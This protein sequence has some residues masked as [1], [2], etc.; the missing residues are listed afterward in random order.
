MKLLES[1]KLGCF[2]LAVISLFLIG[3]S[4]ADQT[5]R[6]SLN[7]DLTGLR[8][9]VEKKGAYVAPE[10]EFR[11]SAGAGWGVYFTAER[12]KR[13]ERMFNAFKIPRSLLLCNTS[14]NGNLLEVVATE[15]TAN[16]T[17]WEPFFKSLP[18]N[19]NLIW[20]WS[21]DELDDLDNVFLTNRAREL[22]AEKTAAY[23]RL[24]QTLKQPLSFDEFTVLDFWVDS[25]SFNVEGWYCL[26]PFADIPNHGS[27]APL[28]TWGWERNSSD[29]SHYFS[30]YS[31]DVPE[32][33]REFRIKYK[34]NLNN[35]YALIDYGFVD[36][37]SELQRVDLELPNDDSLVLEQQQYI[38]KRIVLS[39]NVDIV[40]ILRFCRVLVATSHELYSGRLHLDH[41]IQFFDNPVSTQREI[42]AALG[43]LTHIR[44]LHPT[45]A[46]HRK[47][48]QVYFDKG[49]HSRHRIALEYT[50]AYDRLFER[51]AR[52]CE[53]YAERI[54]C[55]SGHGLYRWWKLLGVSKISKS[56]VAKLTEHLYKKGPAELCR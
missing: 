39:Y 23:Q 21:D 27:D 26:A 11:E 12:P 45:E 31:D 52:F 20:T 47:E 53:R 2:H 1:A 38:L 44:T 4:Y 48:F 25:R 19:A 37:D 13:R 6:W 35:E 18:T 3:F 24:L 8:S 49:V 51:T 7:R 15:F 34:E 17:Y 14:A 32:A 33:D 42:D 46:L 43:C 54:K 36:P 55:F 28:A 22:Q 16:Y 40:R 56:I 9:F 50:L 29:G 30:L 10:F 41:S 5:P